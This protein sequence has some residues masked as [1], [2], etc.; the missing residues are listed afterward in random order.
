[1]Q[2]AVVLLPAYNEKE[3]LKT[4][5]PAIFDEQK[6]ISGWDLHIL[7]I[8]DNS[9]DGTI[10][11]IKSMQKS[12]KKLHLITGQKKG[13]GDAYRRA[14]KHVLDTMSADIV[15]EMD[16]DWQHPPTL[17]PRFIKD[18]DGG[19]DFVIGSRYIRGG[20]I[21]SNWELHRK[22]FSFVGNLVLQV[23]FMRFRIRDWTSGY[24]AIRTSFL[25]KSLP[26]YEGFDGYTI[27]IALLDNA[28]K[29]RLKISEVPL[30]FQDRKIGE[31]KI[32]T[33][34]FVIRNLLYIAQYSTFFKFA[35]VGLIGAGVDFGISFLGLHYTSLAV[36]LVTVISAEFAMISNFTLNNTWSFSHKKIHSS[37]KRDLA[38][39][40]GRFQILS[41]GSIMIQAVLM[42]ISIML[43][44]RKFWYVYKVVIIACCIIPY[45][46]ILYNKVI[47]KDK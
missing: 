33:L 5:I 22:F 6:N 30:K 19:S 4:L 35:V 21:P 7:V 14:F 32:N 47:W 37:Q 11:E 43:F 27:Q 31:S 8:D 18:I 15:F 28:I 2:K 45:S 20:S 42:E 1:M 25:Q 41:I 40:F 26:E 12:M 24:R 10:G 34:D 46:Y 36:W 29:S 17:I 39:A 16:A 3:N 38:T 13:L 9:P 44:P 23:G